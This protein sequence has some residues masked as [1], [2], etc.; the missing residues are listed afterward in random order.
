[1]IRVIMSDF[2]EMCKAGFTSLEYSEHEKQY[3][4]S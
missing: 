4:L 2:S 1:M 3:V